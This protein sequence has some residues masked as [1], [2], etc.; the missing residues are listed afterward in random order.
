MRKR[1]YPLLLAGLSLGLLSASVVRAAEPD[2]RLVAAVRERDQTKVDTLLRAKVDVNI[3]DADGSTPLAWAAHLGERRMAEVLLKSGADV[4]LAD[5]YG[6][7]PLT[8]ACANGDGALVTA[9]LNAGAKAGAARW[10]G[11]TALMLAAGAGSLEAVKALVAHGADVNASEPRRGQTALMWAAAEGQEA[12]IRGLVDLGAKVNTTSSTGFSPLVFAILKGDGPSVRALL[13]ANADANMALPSGTRPLLIALANNRSDAAMALIEGGALVTSQEER[14]GMTPLHLAAQ[15][16]N[17][18]AVNALLAR[19][20]EPNAR[21]KRTP[22]PST[23]WTGDG[24][25]PLVGEQT[26]LMLAARRDHEEVMRALVAAGADPALRAQDGTTLLMAAATSAKPK[27]VRYAF[28]LDPH[29]DVLTE[30][31]TS[32]MHLAVTL[33]N[34]TQPQVVEIVQFLADHGAALDELDAKGKTPLVLADFLPV[35]L[36]VDLL[37]KLITARGDKPKIASSR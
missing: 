7:T 17:L 23:P 31:K 33:G 14:T 18:K 3:A 34:R 21:T 8:L 32:V 5:T 12:V 19:K 26:P 22:P 9:L 28:E 16:G 35:D 6:E 2:R 29:V 11:E 4:H 13:A 36:A 20:A 30:D 10:N 27:T 24:P 25:R 37:T 15:Q 1:R